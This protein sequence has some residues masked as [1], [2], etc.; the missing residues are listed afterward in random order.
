MTALVPTIGHQ[1]LLEFASQYPTL[2]K[3]HVILS[4]LPQEPIHGHLRYEA[5]INQFRDNRRLVF[6]HM[7]KIMPQ[8]PEDHP[9]FWQ[10]WRREIVEH[11]GF[12]FQPDDV[13]IASEL[14]GIK[15][16]ETLGC[17]FAPCDIARQVFPVKGT[18]VRKNL[19]WHFNGIM[20][21]FRWYFQ[22]H[23]VLFGQESVGKTTMAKRLAD[24]FE[25]TYVPEWAREYLETIG[26]EVTT[27]KMNTIVQGQYASLKAVHSMSQTPFVFYDTDLLSTIGYYGIFDVDV[28]PVFADSCFEATRND[29]YVLMPD[30]IPFEQDVLRYGGNKRESTMDYWRELLEDYGCEYI[31]CPSGNHQQQFEYLYEYLTKWYNQEYSHVSSYKR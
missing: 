7:T 1:Y 23:V 3:V 18:E 13:V 21:S 10:M 2:E 24:E 30:T 12:E 11:V 8:Q 16:A 19:Q 15:L 25:C 6:H 28:R 20:P 29:L 22:K 14:Y 17:K 5:F 9:D 4:S 27:E 26:P 31:V